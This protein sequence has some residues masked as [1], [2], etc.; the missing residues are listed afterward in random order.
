MLATVRALPSLEPWA[1]FLADVS[2]R[3]LRGERADKAE[4]DGL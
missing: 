3:A 1:Y 2:L 4:R